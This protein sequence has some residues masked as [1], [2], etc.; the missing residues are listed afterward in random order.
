MGLKLKDL[1][2]ITKNNC[3]HQINLSLKKKELK[4]LNISENKL[5][6]MKLDSKLNAML[7]KN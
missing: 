7:F 4:K 1:F 3:N 2:S 6:N 5:L